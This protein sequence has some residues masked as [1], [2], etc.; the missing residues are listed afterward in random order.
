MH[1]WRMY[2]L[3][4]HGAEGRPMVLQAPATPGYPPEAICTR[5]KS[6][7]ADLIV[8]GKHNANNIEDWLLG[9]VSKAVTHDAE[10]DVLLNN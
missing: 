6:L 9:S 4:S 3:P 7:N 10:C 2:H 1:L 8:I 5:A